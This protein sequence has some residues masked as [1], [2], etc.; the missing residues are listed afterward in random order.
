MV[1]GQPVRRAAVLASPTGGGDAVSH[2][3]RL[4]GVP[5]AARADTAPAAPA[6]AAHAGRHRHRLAA[7]RGVAPTRAL[8][9]RCAPEC[10]RDAGAAVPPVRAV[11]G[12]CFRA[13]S[14]APGRSWPQGTGRRRG[15][16]V[17]GAE[18]LLPVQVSAGGAGPQRHRR[19]RAA[20]RRRVLRGQ[21]LGNDDHLDEGARN[22][23]IGPARGGPDRVRDERRDPS[24]R[25]FRHPGGIRP[26]PARIAA[27]L[28]LDGR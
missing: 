28:L 9:A 27:V 2:G 21:D 23:R 25:L 4:R 24:Q 8:A 6:A 17:Q 11:S 19:L 14:K 3:G 15:A 18:G 7:A 5:E 12:G 1:A 13:R 16:R 26:L 10:R 20:R 22:P